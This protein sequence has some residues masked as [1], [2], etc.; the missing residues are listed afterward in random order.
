MGGWTRAR[1]VV[2]MILVAVV[3]AGWQIFSYQHERA[4]IDES[5]HQQAHSIINAMVGGISSHRR[6]GYG[7][8]DQIQGML[9]ELVTSDDV[10]AAAFVSP[11][12]T[13]PIS[14]GHT[15]RLKLE[16][17]LEP[18]DRLNA[19]GFQMIEEFHLPP[20][21]RGGG[22]GQGRGYGRGL[23]PWSRNQLDAGN[24]PFA[25]EGDYW[26]VLLLDRSRSDA[27]K[28]HAVQSHILSLVAGLLVIGLVGLSWRA[29][30]KMVAARGQTRLLEAETQHLRDL[31]QAA[32]GLA[33]ETRN[34][35]GLIRGWTQRLAHADGD[36]HMRQQH[37]HAVIEECDRVTARINQFLAYAK[38]Q[39]PTLENVDLSQLVGELA[40]L[41]QPDL[42]AK[43]ITLKQD[44]KAKCAVVR[45]DRELLRQS[46]FNLIQNAI[47][48]SPRGETVRVE[49]A[50][51]RDGVC[52]IRVADRGPGV[53]A[54]LV[55]SLFTPYVTTRS[56]GTGLGLAI[57][58]KIADMHGWRVRYQ[59]REGGG[60][61]FTLEGM[62]G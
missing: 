9:D 2:V 44:L 60:S 24:S 39:S 31:G 43:E 45:V 8:D 18:G 3:F 4:L 19:H 58:R 40:T 49:S 15:D 17:P 52:C 47:Q 51:G 28:L 42:D 61:V 56:N 26:A 59:P 13:A 48:F 37:A 25:E 1:V 50:T 33:H 36:D 7:F 34:P 14:A 16:D 53:A 38:P 46:L 20:A 10:L 6:L 54:E 11:L 5:L 30:V 41:L 29:N 23:G 27:L 35:L 62:H 32:A 12:S 55:D 22:G 21:G 57:V